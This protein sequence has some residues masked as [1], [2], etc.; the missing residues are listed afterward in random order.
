MIP[1]DVIDRILSL[2]NIVDVIGEDITLK[3]AGV[4]YKGL[5]PFHDDST[6]SMVVSPVKGIYKCFACGEGGNVVNWLQKHHNMTYPEAIRYLG[7]KVG[8]DVPEEQLSPEERRRNDDK[9]STKAVIVAAQEIYRANL[10][11]AATALEYLTRREITRDTIE[12]YGIGYSCGN[13]K[14][15]QLLTGKGYKVEFMKMAD[16]IREGEDK[17]VYD[18]FRKRIMLPFYN[19]R[20][21]IVGYTGR[22]V[23]GDSAAKYLNTNDTVLFNK[24]SNIWGL[25]QAQNEIKKADE[26][27]IVEGQ[28]DVLSLHQRGV[29]NVVAGSGTAFTDVQMKM[30]KCLTT[31]VTFIYD[32]DAAGV[33][34]AEKNVPQMVKCG[35]NVR[36]ISLP[37]NMDPDDLA[38]Q[39]GSKVG[40]WLN[41]ED[42]DKI[43][44]E[45]YSLLL[46]E[47]FIPKATIK[48]L[49]IFG[50]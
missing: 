39:Q 28:F 45:K 10:E 43:I 19:R 27:Y 20:G 49:V 23:T 24:G 3:K 16:L 12:D 15:S 35:C 8:V 44:L 38:R 25:F 46:E 31:N 32:G 30:I 29:R 37:V 34:A 33:H 4:N 14:M 42:A 6:P 17:R 9:E 11:S 1:Q 26:V 50:K 5:C 22:D 7:E 13:S 21:E 47:N 48:V 2:T 18:T 36:C 40:D 41:R